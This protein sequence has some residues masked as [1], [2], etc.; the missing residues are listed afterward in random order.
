MFIPYIIG[1][2]MYVAAFAADYMG[3]NIAAGVI[4]IA[5]AIIL[6]VYFYKKDKCFVSFRF[7]LSVFWIGGEGLAAF[8]LSHLHPQWTAVTWLCFALF[9][10]VFLL[11]YDLAYH[12]NITDYKKFAW[13]KKKGRK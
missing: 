6:G 7:L 9:Y 2:L 5:E 3:N 12:W 4:L 10:F 13:L 8:R 1:I 11:G